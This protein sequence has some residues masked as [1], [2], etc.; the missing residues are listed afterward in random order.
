M[1]EQDD[2]LDTING[3]SGL[4]SDIIPP[5]INFL[6]PLASWFTCT[7]DFTEIVQR[8]LYYNALRQLVSVNIV[9]HATAGWTQYLFR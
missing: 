5:N 8:L 3:I 7:G 4:C 9:D 6:G 2:K 1:F